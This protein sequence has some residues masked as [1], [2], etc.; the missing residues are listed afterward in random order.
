MVLSKLEKEPEVIRSIERCGM[1]LEQQE[2]Y[3][4]IEAFRFDEGRAEFP[5]I[6]RLAR[7]NGWSIGYTARVVTEYR[8]FTFLAVEAGHPVT[9]S[10]QVDQVW[11]L[12]IL[13]TRSYW[14]RFCKQVLR[15]PLHHGP[16]KGGDSERS[17]FTDWYSKTK[18]SY[19]RFFGEELPVDIWPNADTRFGEDIHYERVNTK[20]AWVIPKRWFR[21][22]AL[23][24]LLIP[25]VSFLLQ[26]C[27][28][29]G[30]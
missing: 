29:C 30:G 21:R 9:P 26:G 12:H 28:G 7:D 24:A 5:F 16:T 22:V 3:H 13:Y 27:G 11:H 25:G 17:K 15:T 18:E 1:T 23:A 10:D 20:R 2:L 8:R 19:R 14:D 6:A 4:R